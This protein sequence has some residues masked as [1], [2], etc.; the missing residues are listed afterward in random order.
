[1]SRGSRFSSI[2]TWFREANA[3]EVR[4]IMPLVLEACGKRHI[5]ISTAAVARKQRSRR[6]NEGDVISKPNSQ[7]ATT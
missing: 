3:D 4:A 1:M 2:L 5:L 7:G 6:L